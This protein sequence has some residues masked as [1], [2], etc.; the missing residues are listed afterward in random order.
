[1][2]RLMPG[3]HKIGSLTVHSGGRI[4]LPG[5]GSVALDV[6]GSFRWEGSFQGNGIQ[7][8]AS[9]LKI[10]TLGSQDIFLNASFGGLHQNTRFLWVR[11][12]NQQGLN[13]AKLNQ[14]GIHKTH[15]VKFPINTRIQ[16]FS[17]GDFWKKF[18]LH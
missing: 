10:R 5:S 2:L 16:L 11:P 14:G 8:A 15:R 1:V 3:E 4:E 9:R 12:G 18:F 7:E 17:Q 13:I 6:A